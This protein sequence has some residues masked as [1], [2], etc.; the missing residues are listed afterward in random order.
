MSAPNDD[1]DV[2]A[3]LL[4]AVQAGDAEIAGVNEKGE[5]TYRLTD[6]GRARVEA[7]LRKA[8]I[9]PE[10]VKPNGVRS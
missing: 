6:Q 2:E 4:E 3:G 5:T 8:G 10:A 9:D 1:L 7:M